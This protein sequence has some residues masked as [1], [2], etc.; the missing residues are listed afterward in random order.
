MKR[1]RKTS[2]EEEDEE[3]SVSDDSMADDAAVVAHNGNGNLKGKAKKEDKGTNKAKKIKTEPNG[4]I[5]TA[6]IAAAEDTTKTATDTP[7][8]VNYEEKFKT[9]CLRKIV[10]ENHGSPIK[11]VAFNNTKECNT[12]LLVTVGDNQVT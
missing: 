8:S 3:I 11:Q 1:R 10:K 4:I 2:R 5:D 9:M 6:T 12:N 7:A